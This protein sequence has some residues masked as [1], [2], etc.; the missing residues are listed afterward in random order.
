MHDAHA[1]LVWTVR[2]PSLGYMMIIEAFLD[3]FLSLLEML[4]WSLLREI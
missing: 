2:H 1:A 4:V 3:S